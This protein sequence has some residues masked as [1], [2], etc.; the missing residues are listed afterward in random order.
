MGE[1]PTGFPRLVPQVRCMCRENRFPKEAEGTNETVHC[2]VTN[3]CLALDIL[4]PLPV[5]DM[6]NKYLLVV[7]DYFF[8]W[9]EAFPIPDQEA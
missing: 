7:A 1:L 4:G 9:I 6:G 5:T 2:G 8:T 3:E